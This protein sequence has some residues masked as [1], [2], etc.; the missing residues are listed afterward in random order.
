MWNSNV[1]TVTRVR[2]FGSVTL[3]NDTFP[4]VITVTRVRD[5]APVLAGN[6]TPSPHAR[7][8]EVDL[9]VCVD[10]VWALEAVVGSG[11][12]FGV[13]VTKVDDPG[14][15]VDEKLLLALAVLDPVEAHVDGFGSFLFDGF[16]GE[17]HRCSVVDLDRGGRLGMAHFVEG[18]S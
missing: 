8:Q 9:L 2:E 3:Q 5:C 7:S 18:S 1:F 4:I 16:V 17:P 13:V 10:V 11:V 14:R 12:V 15:V 6:N